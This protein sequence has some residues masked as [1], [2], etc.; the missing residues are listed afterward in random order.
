MQIEYEA[1][2]INIDKQIIR[3]KLSVLGAE[4]IRPEFLQRRVV[5][6]LPEGHGIP[7]GWLRVRDEGGKITMSLK[8]VD[9]TTIYDQKEVLLNI[10]NFDN[11]VIFLESIGSKKKAFQESRREIWKLG[12]VEIMI[13]EWPF[14]EPYVEIEGVSEDAVKLV[15]EQMGFDYSTAVFDSV[16]GQYSTKYGISKEIINQHTPEILFDIENPFLNRKDS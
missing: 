16:D 11:A 5:F 8:V 13:D 3:Q 15:S 12:D 9:G 6:N 1:T 4:L 10:D 14:L 2:F 7:G